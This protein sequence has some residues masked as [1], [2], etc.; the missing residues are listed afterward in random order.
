MSSGDALWFLDPTMLGYAPGLLGL[1][2]RS[3]GSLGV[4]DG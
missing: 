4:F 1:Q 3:G 2:H